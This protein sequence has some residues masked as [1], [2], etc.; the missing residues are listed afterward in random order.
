MAEI[1][2][3]GDVVNSTVSGLTS[4]S[5]EL[6]SLSSG[7]CAAANQIVSAKGFSEYVGGLSSDTFSGYVDQCNSYITGLSDFIRNQQVRILAYN[8]DKDEINAFLSSLNRNEYKRLDLTPISSYI[9]D[10]YKDRMAVRGFASGLAVLGLGLVEGVGEFAETAADLV[11]LAKSIF[12]TPYTKI[13][14]WITGKNTTKALWDKTRAKVSEKKVESAFDRFYANTP[15]GQYLK[16]NVV[17]YDTVRSIG[18]G[19]GYTVALIGANIVT[20][21]LASGGIGAA[22][23]VSA[24]QLGLSAG[25]MG[26]SK[27]TQNAWADGATTGKGL[28]YGAAAGAWEGVQWFLGAKINQ[29]GGMGDKIAQGIFKGASKGV[30][31][32]VFLDTIDSGVEG[33]VQPTLSLIYKDYGGK[34]FSENWKSAFAAN[35][36]WMGV[37]Q[38]AAIGGAMSAFTEFTG[39]RKLL[40]QADNGKYQPMTDAE[41]KASQAKLGMGAE[42]LG[43]AAAAADTAAKNADIGYK[44][45]TDAEIKASQAKLAA[46]DAD[47]VFKSTDPGYKP[48]TDAEIKA[49]QAKLG[50]EVEGSAAVETGAKNV[51]VGGAAAAETAAKNA[52]ADHIFKPTDAEYKPMTAEE[53]KA[54]QAKLGMGAEEGTDLGGGFAK[55]ADAGGAAAAETAVKHADGGLEDALDQK[56]KEIFATEK[57]LWTTADTFDDAAKTVSVDGTDTLASTG[58]TATGT[59][60]AGATTAGTKKFVPIEGTDYVIITDSKGHHFIDWI[61]YDSYQKYIEL[62]KEVAFHNASNS[63]RIFASSYVGEGNGV[64]TSYKTMNGLMRDN[65][66]EYETGLFGGKNIKGINTHG[67]YHNDVVD[68]DYFL[69]LSGAHYNLRGMV[70]LNYKGI[71]DLDQLIRDNPLAENMVSYRKIKPDSA[72]KILRISEADLG[73][74][75][76]FRKAVLGNGGF[77]AEGFLSSSATKNADVIR[78]NKIIY[79]FYNKSGTPALDMRRFGGIPREQEILIAPHTKYKYTDV[80]QEGS[81]WVIKCEVDDAFDSVTAQKIFKSNMDGLFDNYRK[82]ADKW[83]AHNDYE[84]SRPY[85]NRP[86]GVPDG[87]TY[88]FADPAHKT[89]DGL[90]SKLITVDDLDP[91]QSYG[92][93]KIFGS[94]GGPLDSDRDIS[95]LSPELQKLILGDDIPSAVKK[96][97]PLYA[98]APS[99]QQKSDLL[100]YVDEH[101]NEPGGAEKIAAAFAK[102]L[103]EW[104]AQSTSSG[105]KYY[106]FLNLGDNNLPPEQNAKIMTALINEDQAL[107]QQI[108]DASIE[109]LQIFKKRFGMTDEQIKEISESILGKHFVDGQLGHGAD[110][111]HFGE[112]M[113]EPMKAKVQASIDAGK[114]PVI[115]SG[116]SSQYHEAMDQHFTTISNS[117]IGGTYF[118]ESAYTNWDGTATPFKTITLW[119][120]LSSK[121]AQACCEAT[122]PATGMEFDSIKFLYP[123]GKQADQCFGQL[124][125]NQEFPE[126][127]S[128]GTIEKIVL[129]ETDP[130]T[131]EIVRTIDVDIS[132]I[133]DYCEGVDPT[134]DKA[135]ADVIFEMFKK[136]VKEA[137]I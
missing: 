54:S 136:K 33:F 137:L 59:P 82:L 76:S 97:G 81:H 48:M 71:M 25:V 103:D 4:I 124:F 84:L 72:A 50:M 88:W 104:S 8:D 75:A 23:S 69:D 95:K 117:S 15:A 90:P 112:M 46:S 62:N 89:A 32:R 113:E 131:M 110:W 51:D 85:K 83:D 5:N 44:P 19:L 40:K 37:A 11:V 39:A 41:I 114:E 73:D 3:N 86:A 70:D 60:A 134:M 98:E 122:N 106:E 105:A 67:I 42:G 6:S 21:G 57:P 12:A 17:H 78:G 47:Q 20:G 119:E 30:G 49:S 108:A 135:L 22:G 58:A 55:N 120:D 65:L 109:E 36:G 13:Y 34:T 94:I 38:Q 128:Y 133:I 35:G 92:S 53:I 93:Q 91:T 125:K 2:Y 10:D 45:M 68:V 31:T 77:E 18:K 126:I 29:I 118:I 52:D 26:F 87:F 115:W 99:F 102:K 96:T 111:K 28:T 63:Q 16:N 27:N 80:V 130:N 56:A 107:R 100:K 129:S 43:E 61:D 74:F 66:F 101:I 64:P 123:A 1:Y 24:A 14:D 121:Y 132:D 9:T 116:F 7:L 79:E 127:V